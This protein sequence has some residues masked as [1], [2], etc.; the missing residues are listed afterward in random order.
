LAGVARLTGASLVVRLHQACAFLATVAATLLRAKTPGSDFF[1]PGRVIRISDGA[2][3]SKPGG[4]GTDWR[5]HAVYDLGAGGFSHFD[6]T[7]KHG[8]EALGRGVAI[9]GESRL[10]DR[11][12]AIARG[13]ASSRARGGTRTSTMSRDRAGVPRA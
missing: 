10:S 11:N 12:Y 1:W 5:A 7:D 2:C 6:V 3:V 8:G 4:K 9:P 13:F